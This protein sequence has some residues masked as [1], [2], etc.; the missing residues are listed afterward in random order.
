MSMRRRLDGLKEIL[1]TRTVIRVDRR[2]ID[3]DYL[4]GFLV[5]LA[6]RH[7]LLHLID[8]NVY[9]NGYAALRARDIAGWKVL[10]H[11]TSFLPRAVQLKGFAPVA[12]P[13]IDLSGVPALVASANAQYPLITLHCEA[14]TPDSCW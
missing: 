4:E 12:R 7:L 6:P 1:G 10:E 13:E 9:M 2:P 11:A 5:G 3:P 14:T 8:P